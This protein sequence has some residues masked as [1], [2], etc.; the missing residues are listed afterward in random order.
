MLLA[1]NPYPKTTYRE[2]DAPF[3]FG[4]EAQLRELLQKLIRQRLVF[5]S[6]TANVGKTSLLHGGLMAHLKEAGY[7]GLAGL[8][9]K[10]SSFIPDSNPMEDLV[11]AIARRGILHPDHKMTPDYQDTIRKRLLQKNGQGLIDAYWESGSIKNYNLLIMV[12]P[13]DYFFSL[14][15]NDKH[16]LFIQTLMQAS[17]D[18]ETPIYVIFGLRNSSLSLIAEKYPELENPLSMGQYAIYPLS[19]RELD[20]AIRGPIHATQGEVEDALRIKLLGKFFQAEDQLT[21]LQSTLCQVWQIWYS[22]GKKGPI[23]MKHY[24]RAMKEIEIEVKEKGKKVQINQAPTKAEAQ[25]LEAQLVESED[26]PPLEVL[27][28]PQLAEKAYHALSKADQRLTQALLKA[29]IKKNKTTNG[30]AESFPGMIE[31]LGLVIGVHPDQVMALAQPFREAEI[32]LIQPAISEK[33]NHYS[34]LEISRIAWV[35][36]WPQLRVWVEEEEKEANYYF[37]LVEKIKK[38]PTLAGA[39]KE[40]A[41]RWWKHKQPSQAWAEQYAFDFEEV[42]TYLNRLSGRG[43]A[44]GSASSPPPVSPPP[45]PKSNPN[46]GSSIKARPRIKINPKKK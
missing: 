10:V 40:N 41:L 27:N 43:N 11:Q 42:Q 30:K 34:N 2:K 8:Q 3:F 17:Q 14:A 9:W 13:S 18:P 1:Q 45:S 36:E 26:L 5:L 33:I 7:K 16:R 31:D 25:I 15:A 12:D 28:P 46:K 29:L 6:G 32:E 39:D 23:S 44:K 20:A 24:S 35:Q 37:E 21:E 4:R 19:Q 38:G 22:E